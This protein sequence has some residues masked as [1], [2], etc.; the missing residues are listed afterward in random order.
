MTMPQSRRSCASI[1]GVEVALFPQEARVLERLLLAR[2]GL[3]THDEIIAAVWPDPDQ[4]PEN[5]LGQ[6]R[7]IVGW[8]RAKGIPVE[9]RHSQGYSLRDIKGRSA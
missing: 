3:A 5:A 1:E 6:V 2:P 4:E 7:M 9:L 8:L